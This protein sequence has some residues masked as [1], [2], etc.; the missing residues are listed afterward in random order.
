MRLGTT[1][2]SLSVSRMMAM[3]LSMSSRMRSRPWSRWS[4]SF[5]FPRE[6]NTRRRTH[7]VRQAHHS[8]RSSRTPITRGIPPT[9]TLKLQETES[10]RVVERKSFAM[11]LSGSTPRLRST[12]S[13]RPLRS[14]SSRMSLTS[15][16]FP[17]LMSSATLSI[18]ASVVVV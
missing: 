14:V 10:W 3:A 13:L 6:K 8:S 16:S 15:R 1:S 17:D 2:D 5:F 4:F 7:S 11:S 12:A 9:R 18:T